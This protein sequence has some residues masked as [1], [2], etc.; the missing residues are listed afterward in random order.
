[1]W[2]GSIDHIQN[3]VISPLLVK[4]LGHTT[5]NIYYLDDFLVLKTTRFD[6]KVTFSNRASCIILF[7]KL[8]QFEYHVVNVRFHDFIEAEVIFY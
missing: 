3:F 7:L 5:R 2:Y 4:L 8:Y 6:L 1:M